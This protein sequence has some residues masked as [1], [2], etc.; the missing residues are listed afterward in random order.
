M[1]SNNHHKKSSRQGIRVHPLY[2]VLLVTINLI[3]LMVMGWP[4]VRERMPRFFTETPTPTLTPTLTSTPTPTVTASP[5]ATAT[6]ISPPLNP[7][8]TP[9]PTPATYNFAPSHG[10]LI[11]SLREGGDTHLFAYRPFAEPSGETYTAL[12]LTRL[13]SGEQNDITPAFSPDGKS[14]AFASNRS[15]AWDIY[16]LTLED[17]EIRQL[18][19]TAAYEAHPSWSPDGMWLAFEAYVDGNLEVML[20]DIAQGNAAINLSNHPGADYAPAWSSGGRKISFVSTRGGRT[21]VWLADLD[22]QEEAKRFSQVS[23]DTALSAKHPAWSPNGQY[24]AWAEIT[25]EGVHQLYIWDSTQLDLG[26]TPSGSGDWPVWGGDLLFTN[27]ETPLDAFLTAYPLEESTPPQVMLPAVRLPGPVEGLA[28]GEGLSL[29]TLG[30]SSAAITPAPLWQ[31]RISSA[32]TSGGRY[33][34]VDIPNLAAPYPQLHDLAN[35]SFSA[36]R[37]KVAQKVGWDFL[38]TLGNAYVPLTAPPDPNQAMSWLYT[39]RGFTLS[40]LPRQAEWMMVVREEYGAQMYWRVYVRALSQSGDLGR[41]LHELAWDFD[42][43]YGGTSLE[44]EQGGVTAQA[45]PS[46][47]WVDFT[48][49]AAEYGWERLPA[50]PLWQSAFPSSRFHEFAF[51]EGLTWEAA[52]LEIY[53]PEALYTPTAVPEE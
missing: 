33:D 17:G 26:P 12:P 46:G 40:D 36:L 1:T 14:L 38:G 44:Y 41:P 43:R 4:R 53:P 18:T 21:A 42:A 20:Q 5:T 2:I 23:A 3:V 24:L 51:R 52:M 30:N 7:T 27:V 6:P 8:A 15:G 45:L 29:D 37:E 28:W 25:A 34:L 35:E 9:S 31:A 49:L 47:Y 22:E 32:R 16:I 19:D 50:L 39:G 10:T 48:A 13:T 11:L